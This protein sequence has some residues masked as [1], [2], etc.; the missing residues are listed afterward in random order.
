[1]N[2]SCSMNGSCSQPEGG[3]QV[4]ENIQYTTPNEII[5][6]YYFFMNHPTSLLVG[7]EFG[8][9]VHNARE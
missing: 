8:P 4:V 7:N 1:M 6:N 9:L 3:S 2:D 5:N